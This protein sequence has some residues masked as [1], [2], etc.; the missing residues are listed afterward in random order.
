MR[1][2]PQMKKTVNQSNPQLILSK[3][4]AQDCS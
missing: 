1:K 4:P 3:N 2:A